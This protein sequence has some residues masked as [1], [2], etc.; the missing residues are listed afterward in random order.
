MFPNLGLVFGIL[1]LAVFFLPVF[2]SKQATVTTFDLLGDRNVSGLGKF[3]LVLL[4]VFGLTLLILHFNKASAMVRAVIYVVTGVMP[5]LLGYTSLGGQQN[6][7]MPG[8][9]V[10]ARM[11]LFEVAYLFFCF[12]L[13][14][15]GARPADVLGKL[16]LGIGSGVL[17]IQYLLPAKGPGGESSPLV[18]L[19]VRGMENA[20]GPLVAILAAALLPLVFGL[21]GFVFLSGEYS[22][23]GPQNQQPMG[24]GTMLGLYPA[25][26][27]ALVFLIMAADADQ[28]GFLLTAFWMGT[29]S[30]YAYLVPAVGGASL[31]AQ[32]RK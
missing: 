4:P 2:V 32:V 11:V 28:W 18:V 30:S 17:L 27:L 24:M 10:A 25:F 14:Y 13:I 19:L 23:N 15:R 26:L 21:V 6:Q 31:M 5:L 20:P 22:K 7:F 16:L 9:G 12:A 8:E 3:L 1:L 29:V